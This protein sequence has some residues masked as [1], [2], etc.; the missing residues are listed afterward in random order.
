MNIEIHV[1][2]DD[3]QEKTHNTDGMILIYH[4]P[5]DKNTRVALC[6]E[7]NC[8]EMMIALAQALAKL[9]REV[10]LQAAMIFAVECAVS[11][12]GKTEAE[13]PASAGNEE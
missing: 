3:G 1:M 2:T 9:N 6:G 7:T 4:D 12:R 5:E 11:G 8:T 10:L 13:H